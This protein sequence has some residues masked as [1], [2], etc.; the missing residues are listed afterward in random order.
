MPTS[1]QKNIP[2]VVLSKFNMASPK[3]LI[4]YIKK[5][6]YAYSKVVQVFNQK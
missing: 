1:L 2:T 4:E 3:Q 5:I 6:V